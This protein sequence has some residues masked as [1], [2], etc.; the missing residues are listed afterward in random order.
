MIKVLLVDDHEMVRMGVSAYLSTQPDIEVV[1]EAENGRKGSQLA[2]QLRPDII[3]MDLVMDEMDGVEATRAII[4]EW[5]EA[6][7]VVVTSFLDDEKLYP[8]IEAGATSYLLKTSRA[9]DIADAVR[10]TYDGETVLE[11]KVTGKMMSRMRQKKE[12]PLHDDLTEREFEILLLI[13][14][15]KSNQEIADE[16]FIA[17]KTVKTHV[18]NILNKLNVS[19]RT[20]AVIYAFRHQLTK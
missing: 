7:I 11:P 3:L 13:A 17:L 4:Q 16:L 9:S 19:D 14:E 2:L 5:P 20:Q 15:G 8:V 6:K 10:A 1:G 18:S 12:Q